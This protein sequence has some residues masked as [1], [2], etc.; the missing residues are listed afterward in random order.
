MMQYCC[1]T[2]KGVFDCVWCRG[3]GEGFFHG[4]GR[5]LA[6]QYCCKAWEGVFDCVY[7]VGDMG[8][9][10]SM[11]WEEAAGSLYVWRTCMLNRSLL[12]DI[13]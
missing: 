11:E 4:V 5:M 1:K 7:G 3:N 10:F 12:Y 6:M 9:G 13:F 8:K 2:L